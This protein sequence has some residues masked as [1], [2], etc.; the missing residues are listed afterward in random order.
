MNTKFTPREQ[1]IEVVNRLFYYTDYREWDNLVNEVFSPQVELDM[2]SLV[3]IS[4]F[5][6]SYLAQLRDLRP[7]IAT[8][9]LVSKRHPR[10]DTLM[11]QLGSQTYHPRRTAI[12]A[13]EISLLNLQGFRVY[14]WNVNDQQTMKSMIHAGANGI[15]TDFPQLLASV[16]AE[17]GRV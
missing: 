3:H 17:L 13:A 9:V 15:F 8:G 10:P 16:L 6:Q 7:D 14:V 5:N 1:I 2:V 4:S 12:R 11:R